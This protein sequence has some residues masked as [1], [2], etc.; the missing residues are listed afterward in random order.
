MNCEFENYAT[1][2]QGDFYRT[3][4][5]IT[6]FMQKYPQYSGLVTM[7]NKSKDLGVWNLV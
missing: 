3:K 4:Y 5:N 1:S 7:S 6:L 2:L